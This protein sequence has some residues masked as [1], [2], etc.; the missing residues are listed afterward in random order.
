MGS[1]QS[2]QSKAATRP[3]MTWGMCSGSV[4]ITSDTRPLSTCK[5]DEAR[6]KADGPEG[7]SI[8]IRDFSSTTVHRLCGSDCLS[9]PTIL[10][11]TAAALDQRWFY[12]VLAM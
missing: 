10:F 4:G 12:S 5:A 8:G 3:T 6:K 1:V 11:E 9:F 7:I 2:I